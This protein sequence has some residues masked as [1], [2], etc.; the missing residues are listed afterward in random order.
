MKILAISAC[1]LALLTGVAFSQQQGGENVNSL[2][3]KQDAATFRA[4][5]EQKK[6]Q[7]TEAAYKAALEKIKS[8]TP[9]TDPWAKVRTPNSSTTNHQ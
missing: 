6:R 5:Q 9:P 7:E 8:P 1:T 2:T 3:A 4:M